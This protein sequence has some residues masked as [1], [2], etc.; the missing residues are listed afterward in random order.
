MA[1]SKAVIRLALGYV[2]SIW[3]L[4]LSTNSHDPCYCCCLSTPMILAI[5]GES[6]SQVLRPS[7]QQCSHSAGRTSNDP[8]PFPTVVTISLYTR[9]KASQTVT[10]KYMPHITSRLKTINNIVI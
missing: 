6:A 3:L 5:G 4:L 8:L 7:G 2:S 9:K 1:T 10:L